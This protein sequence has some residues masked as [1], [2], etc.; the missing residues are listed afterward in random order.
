MKCHETLLKLSALLMLTYAC[1]RSTPLIEDKTSY[2]ESVEQ[3]Q[4]DRLE[5][6]KSK[7]GWL[8]LAGIYWLKE[9]EQTFGSHHSNDI[10]FPD[11]AAA[12]IG[13][14]TL[15]DEVAHIKVFDEAFGDFVILER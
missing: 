6:L 13:T 5:D 14:I 9:G 1:N 4:Q 10:V 8:N 2:I 3:W 11:K 12:F 7:D 15:R